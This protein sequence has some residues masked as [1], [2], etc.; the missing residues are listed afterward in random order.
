MSVT[1]SREYAEKIE[2]ETIV[3][4]LE[5]IVRKYLA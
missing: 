1:V 4:I 3:A 5:S 2:A